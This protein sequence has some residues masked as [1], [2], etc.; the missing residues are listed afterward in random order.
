MSPPVERRSLV[1]RGVLDVCLLAL[2]QDQPVYGYELTERLADRGLPVAAGSTYPLLARLEK[3][4]LVATEVRPSTAG[5]PR[6]Y[7]TLSTAGRAALDSG[8]DEW[9]SVAGAVTGLLAPTAA[10]QEVSRA[11]HP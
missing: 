10:A 1:L 11:R 7:Y 9:L 4:G 5:P 3:A 2:L 8:R 6:K